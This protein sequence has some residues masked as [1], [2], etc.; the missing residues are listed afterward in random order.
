MKPSG[1]GF[2]YV[3]LLNGNKVVNYGWGWH[4][5]DFYVTCCN[6]NG[7]MGLAYIPYVAV[8]EDDRG[9]IVNLYNASEID[10]TTPRKRPLKLSLETDFPLTGNVIIEVTPEKKEEFTLKLRIPSWSAN[11]VVKVNGKTQEVA[12]GTYAELT[13]KWQAGDRIEVAF[14]MTRHRRAARQQPQR[15]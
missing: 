13:R 5:G 8:M 14:D 6:L 11:T 9:P 7:P 12:P 1:D 15:R 4:F 10:M 2:S 3:N